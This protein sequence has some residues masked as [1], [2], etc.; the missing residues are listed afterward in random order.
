MSGVIEIF[1]ITEL[2]LLG[3]LVLSV[4]EFQD[5]IIMETA[6]L[7][8]MLFQ[9]HNTVL[10]LGATANSDVSMGF[11]IGDVGFLQKIKF[12][13]RRNFLKFFEDLLK[14]Y[15]MCLEMYAIGLT[16]DRTLALA[17]I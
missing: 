13:K 3:L 2:V 7:L 11:W 17:I 12:T 15:I 14:L 1:L 4:Y 16:H 9:F 6:F 8:N 10:R 5:K